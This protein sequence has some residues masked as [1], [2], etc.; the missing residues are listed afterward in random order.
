MTPDAFLILAER[1]AQESTEAEWRTAASRAYY[2]AF[3]AAK[4]LL[5][6]LGF[7]MPRDDT[8][9]RQV[10]YRLQNCGHPQVVAA[11]AQLDTLRK[12][13]NRADYDLKR[14]F[15]RKQGVV[16]VQ[17]AKSILPLL[18]AADQEPARTQI[19]D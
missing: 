9:H 4:E 2:A 8:A 11:G 19:T 18:S 3:H 12:D 14:V 7:V 13:R 5:A 17:D 15:D 16:P 1:L 10:S 6:V